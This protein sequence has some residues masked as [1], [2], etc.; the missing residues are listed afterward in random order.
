MRSPWP[1]AVV[2]ALFQPTTSA[3]QES[4]HGR[5][6]DGGASFCGQVFLRADGRIFGHEFVEFLFTPSVEGR[7]EAARDRDLDPGAPVRADR[8]ALWWPISADSVGA[9]LAGREGTVWELRLGPGRTT[10]E[11]T[12]RQVLPGEE[13]PHVA[14]AYA[15]TTPCPARD[16]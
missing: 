15:M 7:P 3:A 9:Y 1:V 2:L 8:A 11:G 16:R 5:L 12:L 4:P 14:S 13:S 6:P 10:L